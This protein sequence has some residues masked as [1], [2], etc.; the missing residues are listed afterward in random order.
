[1]DPVVEAL[2]EYKMVLGNL[3]DSRQILN[4][5]KDD[6]LREMAKGELLELEERKENLEEEIKQL[7]IPQDRR[8]KKTPL[9]K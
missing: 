7:L 8:M 1:M 9:L 2:A 6:E 3:Q 4:T 5:A